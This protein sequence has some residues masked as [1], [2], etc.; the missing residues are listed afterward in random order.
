M[1]EGRG[2]ERDRGLLHGLSLSNAVLVSVLDEFLSQDLK[3]LYQ[4]IKLSK[5]N[6]PNN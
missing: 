2:G 5:I 4:E 1:G 3:L 6:I